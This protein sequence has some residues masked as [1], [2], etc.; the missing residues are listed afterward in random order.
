MIRRI[1]RDREQR[2]ESEA[3]FSLVELI[4]VMGIFTMILAVI[5]A[6]IVAMMNQGR[7][8]TGLS[9]NLDTARKIVQDLDT[10]VRY[11]NAITA[12]GTVGTASYVEYQTGNSGQ[13]QT[14]Y[15]WKWDSSTGLVQSRTWLP[16]LTGSTVPTPSAWKTEG[17]GV[18]LMGTTPI[19][20]VPTVLGSTGSKE[21][22]SVSFNATHGSPPT[23]QSD[24]VT[25]A[26]VNTTQNTPLSTAICSQVARS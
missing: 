21:T 13:Q 25:F 8:E 4:V 12:P 19:W 15:Q 7:R 14:C 1:V 11:A 20:A 10:S 16:P 6:S 9:D 2:T 5:T 22:L 3:G 18:S 26:A 17:T 23:T 24:Q